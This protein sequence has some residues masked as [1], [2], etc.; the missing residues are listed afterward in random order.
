MS[1]SLVT[2][3]SIFY[4]YV[5]Y[6]HQNVFFINDSIFMLKRTLTQ[7]RVHYLIK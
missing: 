6:G 4:V 3:A 7:S 2:A 1:Y 5:K